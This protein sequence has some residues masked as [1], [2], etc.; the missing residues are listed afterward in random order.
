V[1]VVC[2]LKALF[3]IRDSQFLE[4][5]NDPKDRSAYVDEWEIIAPEKLQMLKERIKDKFQK[6]CYISSIKLAS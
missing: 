2:L 6:V 5:V 4:T 3:M 1:N